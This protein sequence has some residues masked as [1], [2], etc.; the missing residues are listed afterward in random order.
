MDVMV[1]SSAA[2]IIRNASTRGRL[3][4]AS[5]ARNAARA[6]LSAA[7]HP[8]DEAADGFSTAAADIRIATI[9]LHTNPSPSRV[10]NAARLLWWRSE[11]N[12]EP[13]VPACAKD[14][15]GKVK[16]HQRHLPNL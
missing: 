2:S 6:S 4:S 16:S 5:S 7:E 13:S 3:R 11:P 9:R 10:Q 12:R 1:S 15:T 14:A 8:K